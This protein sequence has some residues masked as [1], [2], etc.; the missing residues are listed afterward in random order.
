MK[1]VGA[2][3]RAKYWTGDVWAEVGGADGAGVF[4]QK[5]GGKMTGTLTV[6]GAL[7]TPGGIHA[8]Y[9]MSLG[10]GVVLDSDIVLRGRSVVFGGSEV[11]GLADPVASTDLA[12]YGYLTSMT[13]GAV[14]KTALPL[15]AAAWQDYG[16]DHEVATVVIGAD[17][18][19]SLGGLVKSKVS[20]AVPSTVGTVPAGFRPSAK[21]VFLCFGGGPSLYRVDVDVNG[22]V[23]LV[24]GGTVPFPADNYLSLSDIAYYMD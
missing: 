10:S 17:G 12:T 22:E 4:L 1:V 11:T 6:N 16:S 2:V 13:S 3:A 21:H 18:M 23:R 5:S 19:V 8:D 14:R 24:D 20:V 15:N 9:Y 7:T